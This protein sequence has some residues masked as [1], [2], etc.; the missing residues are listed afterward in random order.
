MEI[1]KNSNVD[2]SK[3]GWVKKISFLTGIK[4]QKV[5]MWM[6]RYMNDFYEKNC[7]KRMCL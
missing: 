2:F 6:K 3:F 7:F 1:I 4:H 5:S